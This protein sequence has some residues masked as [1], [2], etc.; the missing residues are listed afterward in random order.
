MPTTSFAI[1]TLRIIAILTSGSGLFMVISSIGLNLYMRSLIGEFGMPNL[2]Q[3][4]VMGNNFPASSVSS[5]FS[6]QF[7]I[8]LLVFF[9]GAALYSLSELIGK[10]ITK[11]LT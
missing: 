2:I 10:F 9:G 5:L 4:S 1:V 8:A 7:F 11:D 3:G 6:V